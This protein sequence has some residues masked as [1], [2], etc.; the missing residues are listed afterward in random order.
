MRSAGIRAGLPCL[1]V[2]RLALSHLSTLND[3]TASRVLSDNS[4]LF[5]HRRIQKTP[6]TSGAAGNSASEKSFEKKRC[7]AA[8]SVAG[9][10]FR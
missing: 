3:F 5:L 1:R 10:S 2:P 8:G 6:K 7:G 9:A 4:A